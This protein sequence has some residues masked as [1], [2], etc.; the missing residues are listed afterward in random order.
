MRKHLD[1]IRDKALKAR[2]KKVRCIELNLVFDGL[3]DAERWSLT[4]GNPNGK[5]CSHQQISKVCK[6]HAKTTG[7]YHWEYIKEEKNNES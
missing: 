3:S 6:G 7:G 4:S 1:K 5:K 2:K